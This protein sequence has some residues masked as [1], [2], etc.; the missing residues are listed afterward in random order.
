M[1]RRKKALVLTILCVTNVTMSL[2]VLKCCYFE[3]RNLNF[4]AVGRKVHMFPL[5]HLIHEVS[6]CRHGQYICYLELAIEVCGDWIMRRSRA[7]SPVSLTN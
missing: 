7:H 4:N 5:E 2:E 1:L 3:L 6:R